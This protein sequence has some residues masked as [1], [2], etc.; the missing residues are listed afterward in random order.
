MPYMK[1]LVVAYE[2]S[3]GVPSQEERIYIFPQEESHKDFAEKLFDTSEFWKPIRGGQVMLESGRLM[4]Y[5]E[6]FSLRL[7]GDKVKDTALF[8]RQINQEIDTGR[9]LSVPEEQPLQLPRKDK[10]VCHCGRP[11]RS[12]SK[13]CS[14]EC[15][16]ADASST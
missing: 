13:W 2:A 8:Y 6:A 10:R 11:A 9:G 5:G 1:Y 12:Q 15:R 3:P 7:D 4:C 14:K 16:E